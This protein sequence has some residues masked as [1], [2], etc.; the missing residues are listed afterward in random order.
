MQKSGY[1]AYDTG[2]LDRVTAILGA[3]IPDQEF[4]QRVR[5][6]VGGEGDAAQKG[7]ALWLINKYLN[8]P[9]LRV[10][11]SA[12]I[13]RHEQNHLPPM[14]SID[15]VA[16]NA[17]SEL[18]ATGLTFIPEI[19]SPASVREMR[20]YCAQ[21]LPMLPDG[22]TQYYTIRDTVRI[23]HGLRL[24]THPTILGAVSD[25][26]GMPATIIDISMWASV[27]DAKTVG[28]QLFHRDRDDFR[29]CKLFLYLTDVG[30]DD[31]PH[32]FVRRSH[33][34]GAVKQK[35]GDSLPPEGLSAL[36]TGDGRAVEAHIEQ[37]FKDDVLEITGKAGTCFLEAT[38][39]FHR[40]KVPTKGTRLI[41]QVVY[42]F[43]PFPHRLTRLGDGDLEG[44]PADVPDTPQVRHAMRFLIG[45]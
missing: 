17:A 1:S 19:L 22:S 37:L 11:V 36:F 15:A 24:A 29:A 18:R 28:A 13:A 44:L 23:P 9:V 42:G 38:Y 21:P 4:W 25:Y 20:D 31:G 16:T 7:R 43:T 34:V 14:S 39:G 12:E 33:D 41:Y 30:N 2:L 5:K 40:G 6:N 10:S 26:L 35:F 27:P 45:E 3:A 8:D 32:I